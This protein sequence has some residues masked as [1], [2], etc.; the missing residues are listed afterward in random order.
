MPK[1][2]KEVEDIL[3]R[4]IFDYAKGGISIVSLK[5]DW[6]KVNQSLVNLLGYSEAEL[7]T[8]AFQDITHKDDL[9]KDVSLMHQLLNGDIE[10]YQMEKRY[11]HKDGYIVWA[12]LSVS[13]VR[14]ETNE[15]LYFISQITDMSKQKSASWRFE[16][17]MN[18]I[19][20][21]NKT[22]K[23][24]TYIATHDIRTHIGNMSSISDFLEE[25]FPQIAESESFGM[26][27]ESISNLNATIE[28]LSQIKVDQSIQEQ[29]LD[30]LLLDTY[31]TNATYNVNAIAKKE[32]C[33]IINK[34]EK[35]I[36][37]MGTE[38]YL[39]S[40][41][42]NFLTNA[43][44]YKSH[45]RKPIIELFSE[46]KGQYVVLKIKDNGVGID[47]SKNGSKLFTLNG[48]FNNHHD[49]RGVGLYITKNH[50]ESLGGKI[51]V[52]SVLDKGTCFSLYFLRA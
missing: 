20:G 33:T 27:K 25:D 19:K 9:E 45:N 44:K 10:S 52:E 28:H 37:I 11:F 2:F 18:V 8:M 1:N 14:S 41:I 24:F 30:V 40:I 22:L 32:N 39:D 7:Y 15:P 35:D 50:I 29:N 51:E 23:D 42:L 31:I 13:L 12:L 38:A 49:S 43:I 47:L 6:V 16:F 17:L 5:G 26:L 34:V 4:K 21:Q 48:T 46:I 3:Y 36:K